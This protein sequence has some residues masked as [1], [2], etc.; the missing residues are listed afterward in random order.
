MNFY[1]EV[2]RAERSSERVQRKRALFLC[3]TPFQAYL[4]YKIA[5]SERFAAL[6]VIYISRNNSPKDIYYF[7]KI[8]S[9]SD[10]EF[11]FYHPESSNFVFGYLKLLTIFPTWLLKTRYDSI[12]IASINVWYF[13]AIAKFKKSSADIYTYD[14]GSGNFFK[15][16]EA[17][18]KKVRLKDRIF[19]TPVI[20]LSVAEIIKL[21]KRHYTVNSSLTNIVDPNRIKQIDMRV[22]SNKRGKGNNIL[23]IFIGQNFSEYLSQ[24]EV[25]RVHNFLG[26]M[27]CE[28]LP[29]PREKIQKTRFEGNIHVIKTEKIIEDYI[30]EMLSEYSHVEVY[31]AFSTAL[32]TINFDNVDKFYLSVDGS[33]ER[34]RI[35]KDCGCRIEKI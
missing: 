14:D 24:S 34:E 32:I 8:K 16:G 1:Y 4:C 2:S 25:S 5:Q 22:E 29:H 31:G 12:F 28:Y 27:N 13:R 30:E 35:M 21:A 9:I 7:E 18:K 6:D 3:R 33:E 19:N 26:N 11:Y 10:R 20:G 17:L 15:K 23:K